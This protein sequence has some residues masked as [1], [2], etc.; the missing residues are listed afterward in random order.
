MQ[1][2]SSELI[3][4]AKILSIC[5]AGGVDKVRVVKLDNTFTR[6]GHA[7]DREGWNDDSGFQE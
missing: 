7:T 5:H 1:P 4:D 2:S 3:C 6:R